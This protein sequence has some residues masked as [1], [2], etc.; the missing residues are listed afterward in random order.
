[1]AER[2]VREPWFS[3]IA[4]GAKRFE[5]RLGNNASFAAMPPAR[6]TPP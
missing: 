6:N 5:G 2:G 4:V 3:L 1:M